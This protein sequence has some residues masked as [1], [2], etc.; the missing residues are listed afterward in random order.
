M[1][2][3]IVICEKPSQAR[4]IRAAI[5]NRHGQVLPA[6]GH[7]LTLKEPDDIREDWK[8][9][10]AE[11]LWPGKF[12][13]KKPVASTK[14]NLDEI[15]AAA[16]SASRIIIATDCDREGQLIGDEIVEFIGFRGE[17][18]RCIF[19][20]EDPKSLQEAFARLKPNKEF[21][22]L[23]MSGQARE[24]ADQTS[25]LSL[26]R[27]ATVTLKSPGD[28]GAIGIGR[29]KSPVLGIVCRREL[30]IIDFKPQDMFE[31]DAT[32]KVRAGALT[33]TCSR[34]PASLVREQAQAV[35]EGDGE[36]LGADEAALAEA[37]SMVGRIQRR[38]IAEGLRAAVEG[39]AGRLSSKSDRRK[40]APPKLFDLTALQSAASSRF[41]WGGEKTLGIAQS[42][43]SVHTLITYPRGEAKYLPENNIADI[44]KLLPALLGL[45]G[46]GA[47]AQ[48]LESPVVRRGKSGHFSDKALEGMSHYAI[49]P[50]VNT[51][52]QFGRAVKALPEDEKKLFDLIVRQYLAALA[53]DHEYRQ[54]TIDMVFPW[55]GHDWNFRASGRV[56]LIPGWK[57]ILGGM[58]RK[59]TE[60]EPELPAV[61]DGETGKVETASLRTVT[62]KP[63]ARYT[64]GSLIK[65]MQE[66]WRLVQDPQMRARLKEAKG[67]GTPATRGD[68][69]KGLIQQGQIII[70]GKAIHPTEGGLQLYKVLS[71]VCPNVVDPARTAMWETI[72]DMVEKGKISAE[73]AVL[74]ILAETRN[75]IS[76][77]V[78]NAGGLKISIGKSS[79]PT[80][81][82]VDLAKR[83]AERKGIKLPRGVLGDG[84]ACRAFLDEHMPPRDPNA[85]GGAQGGAFPPSDKQLAFAEQ[86]A[87]AAGKKIPDDARASSRLLS[88]WIDKNRKAMPAR[89]PTEKQLALAERLASESGSELAEKVRTDMKACADYIDAMLS[90]SPR[91]SRRGKAT[92]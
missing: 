73:D 8:T 81:R 92:A 34:L 47:H 12:Y 44:P 26:T 5:G 40:Q 60:E 55:R 59:D 85:P 61:Q 30:E 27:T 53:P 80:P 88:E 62:T 4:A 79:R 84:A 3:S 14:R 83:V 41:G 28:K 68:V 90:K 19:N 70:K 66:A 82:M 15:R 23:Y 63:P 18:M 54:T 9:W 69:V 50:N 2:Q 17:V 65:V 16:R 7:L 86:I 13:E 1:S 76:R 49:I 48:L 6:V 87:T 46:Y 58:T 72:F 20:A 51:S 78:S 21:R 45:P 43:Y 38:D 64:E 25:N 32:T 75:E 91:G 33:L 57:A 74:K 29:V 67:I 22:G 39:H 24:Q 36:D 71:Q 35:E 89:P 31:I 10:S 52:D 11:L 77:I 42:L 56:P 37:E